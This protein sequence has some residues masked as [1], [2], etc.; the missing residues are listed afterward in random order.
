QAFK[1]D[2]E[3]WVMVK[4]SGDK[5]IYS[6]V[7]KGADIPLPDDIAVGISNVAA[8]SEWNKPAIDEYAQTTEIWRE[9][10]HRRNRYAD[11]RIKIQHGEIAQI[12]DFITYNLDI[13][14]FA[15]DVIEDCTDAEFLKHF[16]KELTNVTILDP[17]CGSGAFLFAA[18]NMLEQLYESCLTRMRN[19]TDDEDRINKEDRHHFENKYKYFR[20][21]LQET[22]NEQHPNLQYYIYKSIILRNLYGVDIMNE[23]V[24]I[25]K[26]RLF[27][28]LVATVDADHQKPNIGL[29]PLPDIDF[30]I[31]SG[32]TLVG[33]ATKTELNKGGGY[34]LDFDQSMPVIEEKCDIVS[35]AFTRYKE[36]QLSYGEDFKEFKRAKEDLFNR[37][38]ELNHELNI[39]LHKQAPDSEYT[40]WLNNYRPFHW[41]A[42]F[43]EIISR[44]GG[45]NL[46]I[47]NPPYVAIKD[48]SYKPKNF[49]TLECGDAYALCIERAMVSL[50]NKNG[51]IGMI[52]PISIASTDGY[53]S[54]RKIC[55]NSKSGFYFSNYGVRPSKLFDGVDKRLTIFISRGYENSMSFSTKY[56]RWSSVERDFL[57]QNLSYQHVEPNLFSISGYP[58]VS[59][60]H[61][62]N[63][64]NSLVKKRT[65]VSNFIV[66]ASSHKVKYTRKL[67]YFIQFF[68]DPPIIYDN[69]RKVVTPTELKEINFGNNDQK[70]IALALLNSNLFFWFFI[71]FS[72]C[73]NVNSREIMKLP[74]SLDSFEYS[75]SDKLK[76]LS[77]ELMMDFKKNAIFQFRNDKRAGMIE[78]QSFQPRHSKQ[79]IDEI[80]RSLAE[81]YNFNDEELDFI[82]NYDIKYR[83]GK[84][85]ENEDEE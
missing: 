47:G 20:E 46:I 53:S 3:M 65:T 67:Q 34:T 73:R 12:N 59:T 2:G 10:V 7:K 54:L 37:L 82:I 71:V 11:V 83:M 84:D 57:F 77:K 39:L 23:A 24:E 36:I 8:R 41:F 62:I 25:A 21:V 29:E 31:R 42:E 70:E 32:N 55:I 69:K 43:Y 78:I 15:Q 64:L 44:K 85:L 22:Q 5:Y 1:P 61:E 14:Q 58:K 76:R 9:V 63:I 50:L 26:L 30:N 56:Y 27:L 4:Q 40:T 48:I 66:K 80:D 19:F 33:F 72:D 18:M 17:T 45:F 68:E 74:V 79:I 51:R 13:R 60:T 6:T 49:T 75:L 38:K 28:K 35:K 52:V 16:Y 81:Y